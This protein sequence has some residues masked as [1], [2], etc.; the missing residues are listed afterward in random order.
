MELTNRSGK[1]EYWEKAWKNWS[2]PPERRPRHA[3]IAGPG[4]ITFITG[5][6][7]MGA[8][9]LDHETGL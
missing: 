3:D 4:E 6:T 5:Q 2:K 1:R 7:G 8:K 9:Y